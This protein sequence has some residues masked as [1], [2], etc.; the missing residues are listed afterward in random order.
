MVAPGPAAAERAEEQTTT[1]ETAASASAE[2]GGVS[3]APPAVAGGPVGPPPRGP[4]AQW[5]RASRAARV[6]SETFAA[7]LVAEQGGRG[8]GAAGGRPTQQHEQGSRG[9]RPGPSWRS[10][11]PAAGGAH[12]HTG[13][14]EQ[15]EDAD[16]LF[17]QLLSREA[18]QR[19]AEEEEE[20]AHGLVGLVRTR[21]APGLR[22]QQQRD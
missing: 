2:T 8:G 21:R 12:E 13:A 16:A 1:D 22:Q 9:T 14:F 19:K 4:H 6:R 5:S 10:P 18:E 11:Q 20:E 15:A 7:S 17:D 3:A